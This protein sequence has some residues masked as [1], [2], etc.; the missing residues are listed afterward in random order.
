MNINEDIVL[1]SHFDDF[2]QQYDYQDM[3]DSK[4]FELFAIY[5]IVSK[6]IKTDTLSSD[7]LEQFNIGDGND[8]GIDGFIVIVNGKIVTSVQEVDDL[9]NA[10]NYINLNI[11]TVQA[12]TSHNFD[13]GELGLF[14]DGNE[15]FLLDLTNSTELPPSNDKLNECRHLL[16]HIYSKCAVF[17]DGKNPTLDAY[18]VTCGEYN[19][20]PN[21]EVKIQNA[22]KTI[23]DIDLVSRFECNMLGRKDIIRYYKETKSKAEAILKIDNKISL[24]EVANITESYLC[25][26]PFREFKKLIIG[27]DSKIIHS[28]FYDNIRAF[29][30][31]NIVN[32]AMSDFLKH[33]IDNNG[34]ISLFT[35]MNN[36]ITIIAKSIKTTGNNMRISDYQI[37]NGCQTCNVLQQNANING[38]DDLMLTVKIISSDDKDIRDKII[39]GNNS[40]TEVKRE[41]LIALLDTQKQIED[42]FNAQN[43]FEKLYYERR[44]KQYKYEEASIPQYKVITIPFLIKAFVAMIMEKPDQVSGYYGSIVEAFDK[45]DIHV[46]DPQTKPELY[47]TSALAC[48][49]MEKLFK[50]GFISSEYKKIKYHLLLSFK[51]LAQ[52]ERTPQ[53]NNRKIQDYC[54]RICEILCD[55]TKCKT[56]FKHSITLVDLVLGRKPMDSDRS[57]KRFTENIQKK[58]RLYSVQTGALK[59]Q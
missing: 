17:Q 32:K 20:Q 47:Y 33:G 51:L 43:T 21:F 57:D 10:N 7:L 53:F 27:E 16:K 4:A 38:I 12:K 14:L 59:L 40:Q 56:Y 29:Q 2:K 24:P 42:Y 13:S 18:F 3:T 58:S 25:L 30:G 6:Y 48:Y 37:V 50:L 49:M 45:N 55:E 28:V 8:W 41:Q 15:Y 36:G 31:D 22:K 39:V 26:I 52:S 46:F 5:S 34:D 44:S 19:H 9:L 35:A 11:I 23:M 54:N 1:K